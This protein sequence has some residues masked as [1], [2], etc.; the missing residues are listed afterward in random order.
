MYRFIFLASFI[1]VCL[2][3]KEEPASRLPWHRSFYA[4]MKSL[5]K[6]ERVTAAAAVQTANNQVEPGSSLN[7]TISSTTAGN[8]LI[9]SVA[10]DPSITVS[11]VTDN[12]SSSY[13]VGS[14]VSNGGGGSFK[15]Y[16]AYAVANAGVTTVTITASGSGSINAIVD[17]YSGTATS[18]V[19]DVRATNSGTGTS[20]SVSLTPSAS[21]KLIVCTLLG[22]LA[23]TWTAG[24]GYTLYGVLNY[25][26]VSEIMRTQYKL[27]GTTS[28]TA[29]A[30]ING[31]V[32][33][34][35]WAE[36]ATAFNPAAS[37]A[38]AAPALNAAGNKPK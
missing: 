25:L 35:G 26:G 13:T 8:L 21:G 9:V 37:G 14:S 27:S 6:P 7:V 24:S 15:V 1:L 18:S 29:P 17:E 20:L 16:Q 19:N 4:E 11:S 5:E 10:V 3:F 32:A 38:T 2:G 31:W 36:I 12:Q 22:P 34:E 30:T 23:T 28:E 33:E